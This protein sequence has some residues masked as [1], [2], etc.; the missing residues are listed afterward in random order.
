[1]TVEVIEVAVEKVAMVSKD[2][3]KQ[4]IDAWQDA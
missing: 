2:A 3:G 1:V 4:G